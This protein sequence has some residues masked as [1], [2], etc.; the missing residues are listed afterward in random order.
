MTELRVQRLHPDSLGELADALATSSL[1]V[2][3]LGEAGRIFFR[4]DDAVG[5]AGY[6]GIEGE[7]SDRLLRSLL[8]V[9]GRRNG[10]LGRSLLA[11]LETVA[12]SV[13]TDRL[14]LLTNA[15]APFFVAN[16]YIAADRA[17]APASIAAS[18]EFTALCPVSADYLVKVL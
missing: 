18:R 10:G 16:G 13:G 1:P 12:G 6:A 11:L 8:V 2:A 15:A 7:G 9:A 3:D 5:L 17:A 4:F 14:H